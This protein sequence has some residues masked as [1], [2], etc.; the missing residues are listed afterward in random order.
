MKK[1]FVTLFLSIL[2]IF[3][4][5]Q[6]VDIDA[7]RFQVEYAQL[8]K[9][10]I[11]GEKSFAVHVDGSHAYRVDGLAD[12]L[13][14]RG[15]EYKDE[16]ALAL[17]KVN[18]GGFSRGK[19][20]VKTDTNKKKDKN[21]NVTTTKKY[22]Y[23][24]TNKGSAHVKIYGPV[25]PYKEPKNK[26]EK[27]K[28]EKKE[29]EKAENPFL[30]NVDISEEPEIEEDHIGELAESSSLNK[31]YIVT[32]E[33]LS[34]RSKAYEDYK[35]KAG[36]AYSNQLDQFYS[37][38]EGRVNNFVNTIYGYKRK[39]E[40]AKFKRL[41]SKKHPEYETYHNA[42]EAM[43]TILMS[44][45]FNKDYSELEPALQPI[46]EYFESVKD[47]YS[48]D[49]KHPKRLKAASMYNLAQMYYYLDMPEKVIAIGEEYL[50]WG[51]DKK[52]GKRFIKKGEKLKSLLEFHGTKRYFLTDENADEVESEDAEELED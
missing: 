1:T 20:D 12:N 45:R 24:S 16:G 23:R 31:S 36:S 30:N 35:S 38:L 41:D 49:K 10:K 42:T 46:I 8:P 2:T 3:I 32:S 27:E 6:K 40:T 34:S 47:K 5:G 26:K 48:E 44:K 39:K 4:Y 51:H 25:N 19:S 52:D 14:I 17:I 7:M 50:A 13:Y 43:K 28:E 21:G 9:H 15:W 33:K 37:G 22:T 29:K 18:V 11:E